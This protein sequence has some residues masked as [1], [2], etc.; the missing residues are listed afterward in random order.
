M[1]LTTDRRSLAAA[2][3]PAA[4]VIKR[5]AEIPV[6][7]HLLID[8]VEGAVSVTADNGNLRVTT[9]CAADVAEPGVLLASGHLLNDIVR[10][11]PDAGAVTLDGGDGIRGTLR[12]GRARFAIPLLAPDGFPEI[13]SEG[14]THRFAVPAAALAGALTLTGFATS[15]EKALYH[16]SGIYMHAAPTGDAAKL[17]FVS[18]NAH[19]LA[20]VEHALPDGAAGMPGVIL[21]GDAAGE[22]ARLATEGI[23][24]VSVSPNLVEFAFGGGTVLTSKLV[25]GRFPDYA[26]IIPADQPKR[27]VLDREA[28]AEAL[29]RVAA[30]AG[31]KATRFAFAPG[32]L[33]LSVDAAEKGAVTEEMEVETADDVTIGYNPAY[34]RDVIA[35]L[36]GDRVEIG[37]T[38]AGSAGSFRTPGQPVPLYLIMP[39][40]V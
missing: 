9:A 34:V 14:Y 4:K 26:R 8:A 22:V 27:V 12:A 10:R 24:A 35:A 6:L 28:F 2:L 33:T 29:D 21:P 36:G 17:C 31:T 32:A 25:D 20:L 7:S 3:A 15:S 5:N 11:C 18:T 37:L 30:V 19:I 13:R 39:V 1:K 40:R 16:L 38:D 23:V